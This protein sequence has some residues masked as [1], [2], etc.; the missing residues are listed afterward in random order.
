MIFRLRKI[1]TYFDH[2]PLYLETCELLPFPLEEPR[3]WGTS[4][5]IHLCEHLWLFPRAGP[6]S[7]ITRSD[8]I[9]VQALRECAAAPSALCWRLNGPHCFH[10]VHVSPAGVQ[11]SPGL[12]T[13][14]VL[15][16]TFGACHHP[17]LVRD[18]L[19]G[20][21]VPLC[22]T[23]TYPSPPPDPTENVRHK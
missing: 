21:I 9:H 23:S 5:H 6:R 1:F 22:F 12:Y 7:G 19:R 18:K 13:G 8:N 11:V 2:F 17:S 4:L 14:T 20:I 3:L 15:K 10:R 16:M